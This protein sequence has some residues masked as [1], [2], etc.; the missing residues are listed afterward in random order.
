MRKVYVGLDVGSKVCAVYAMDSR[1]RHIK[2]SLFNTSGGNM[3]EF[4]EKLNG[5]VHALLEEGELASWTYRTLKPH[6]ETVIVSNPK[7]NSY[8]A[9]SKVKDDMADAKKLA[10][11]LRMNSF[12]PVW[13]PEAESMAAFKI[14]VQHYEEATKRAARLKGQIKA[15]LR[16]QGVIVTGSRVYGK[17]GRT[18]A[19][20]RIKD[21][22]LREM[23]E[24]EFS[25]LDHLER[26]RALSLARMRRASRKYPVIKRLEKIPG[27]GF[28]LA[29]RF[30]SYVQDPHRF[31]KRTLWNYSRLGVSSKESDGNQ[32]GRVHLSNE[33]CGALKDLSNTAFYAALRTKSD[34]GIKRFYH[35]S[36][37]G[38]GDI[39]HARLNTQRKILAIMLAVWRD[40]KD[41]EDDLVV[42]KRAY[43]S[44]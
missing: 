42:G 30:V 39:T 35:S 10:E 7:R 17:T 2:S 23:I 19:V 26:E 11:L 5:K 32:I 33:G 20:S 25:L 43:L 12:D 21:K 37:A 44:A 41:Y 9:K 28:N 6:V 3:I 13:Q 36:L 40:E 14:L 34:N 15:R 22:Y 1:G 4:M 27:I 18:E 8:I 16:R 38:T 31:K 24:Q 29:S